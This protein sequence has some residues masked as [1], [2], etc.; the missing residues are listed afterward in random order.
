MKTA[1]NRLSLFAQGNIKRGY[2]SY[3][4]KQAVKNLA[5]VALLTT[6]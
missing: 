6:L 2:V 1:A 4:P 5:A 3:Y